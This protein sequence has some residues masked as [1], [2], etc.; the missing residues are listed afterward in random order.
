V[1]ASSLTHLGD[2]S[3]AAI[4]GSLHGGDAAESPLEKVLGSYLEDGGG[5]G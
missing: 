2:L 3:N 1:E 5:N 4:P